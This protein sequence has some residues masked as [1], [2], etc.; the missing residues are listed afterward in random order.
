MCEGTFLLQMEDLGMTVGCCNG[1]V[2]TLK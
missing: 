2:E 1:L